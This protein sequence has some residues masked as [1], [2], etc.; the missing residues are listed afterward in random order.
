VHVIAGGVF[1]LELRGGAR[2]RTG[3]QYS[4]KIRNL[5]KSGS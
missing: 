4:E 3:R 1:E 5:L 2:I